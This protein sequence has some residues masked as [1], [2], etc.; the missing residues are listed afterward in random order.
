MAEHKAFLD[1]FDRA[2]E[3][4]CDPMIQALLDREERRLL[5]SASTVARASRAPHDVRG[6]RGL[7]H[8]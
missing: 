7:H 4:D 8:R 6:D 3:D 1:G 5:A 2:E